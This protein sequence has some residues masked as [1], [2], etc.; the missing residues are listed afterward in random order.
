MIANSYQ[1]LPDQATRASVIS[2]S[3]PVSGSG[4]SGVAGVR[5]TGNKNCDH[6]QHQ[7]RI[8]SGMRAMKISQDCSRDTLEVV[9]E[10]DDEDEDILS[11]SDNNDKTQLLSRNNTTPVSHTSLSTTTVDQSENDKD[12]ETLKTDIMNCQVLLEKLSSKIRVGADIRL[13]SAGD[14]IQIYPLAGAFLGTCL[15]GPVGFLAGVKIGGLAAVGGG[16]L[17]KNI[18]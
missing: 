10:E 16:I 18:L 3:V 5:R 9:Y 17:G 4:H 11:C 6:H 12:W 7:Q 8:N 13:V 2:S 14:A 1:I 15:G